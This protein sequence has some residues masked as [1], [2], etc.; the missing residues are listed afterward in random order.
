MGL[1]MSVLLDL[2]RESLGSWCISKPIV[3]K[4]HYSGVN[5]GKICRVADKQKTP[6][7]NTGARNLGNQPLYRSKT[8]SLTLR[9]P[10]P[11]AFYSGHV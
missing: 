7:T 8:T 1:R 6:I 2:A 3:H 5:I 4:R 10:L 11:V 9:K